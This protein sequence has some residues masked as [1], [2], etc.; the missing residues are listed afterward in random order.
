[1]ITVV[2]VLAIFVGHAVP[3]VESARNT[4]QH[5]PIVY[6]VENVDTEACPSEDILYPCRCSQQ[7]MVDIVKTM[8]LCNQTEVA[9]TGLHTIDHVLKRISKRLMKHP[10]KRYFDW[11]YLLNLGPTVH[12][13]S[14]NYFSGIR[15][16]NLV[17][18]NAPQLKYLHPSSMKAMNNL[19]RYFYAYNTGLE[20]Y[21]TIPFKSPF[22]SLRNLTEVHIASE[23]NICPPK[24]KFR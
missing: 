9:R 21:R 17:I 19:L 15:F 13:L 16:A 22:G 18:W 4:T 8:L 2:L 12:K 3:L 7:V 10:R 1:M 14:K 23:R 20:Y 24:G 5:V 11:L 6:T